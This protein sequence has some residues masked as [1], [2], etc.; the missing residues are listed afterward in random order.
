MLFVLVSPISLRSHYFESRL[1]TAVNVSVYSTSKGYG[2]LYEQIM[3]Q[4]FSTFWMQK[5]NTAFLAP[6]GGLKLTRYNAVY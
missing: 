5:I 2:A 6:H 3:T 4:E 1:S